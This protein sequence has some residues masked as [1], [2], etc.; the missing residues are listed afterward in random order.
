MKYNLKTIK[1]Q[2]YSENSDVRKIDL[3]YSPG[4]ISQNRSSVSQ[5][6]RTRIRIQIPRSGF[7]LLVHRPSQSKVILKKLESSPLAQK[8]FQTF[9]KSGLEGSN[10]SQGEQAL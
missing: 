3:K 9:Q 1:N 10:R 4:S 7:F 6:N 2:D 5:K 8:G